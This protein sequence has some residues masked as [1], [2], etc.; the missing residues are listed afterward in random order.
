MND[1]RR[2][3]NKYDVLIFAAVLAV[4]VAFAL[5]PGNGEGGAECQIEHRGE[6]ILA[7]LGEDQT[8]HFNDSGNLTV[9]IKNGAAAITE[10]PCPDKRCV[11]TGFIS[12]PGQMTV[13]LPER[14]A[15]I[16]RAAK[17]PGIDAVSG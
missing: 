10:S 7:S 2:F 8:F 14:T 15:V 3:I 11:K 6:K 12:R 4:C 17:K 1:K 16:I 9:E 5:L 13:C